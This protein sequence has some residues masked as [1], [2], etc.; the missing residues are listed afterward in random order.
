MMSTEMA[1]NITEMAEMNTENVDMTTEMAENVP[2]VAENNQLA[3]TNE[4]K[5]ARLATEIN[6]IKI[7]TQAVIQNATLEIGRRLVQ[8][9]AAVPHGCWGQWLKEKVDYS[10]RTAQMLISTFER[11]GNG[12]Q[13]L[14]GKTAD[15]E[16][17]AQLNRSQ[18][19][20]LM[21]IKNEDDCIAFMDEHKEDLPSMSKRELEQAIKER[22]QAKADIE[23]WR[24]RCNDLTDT[25]EKAAQRAEKLKAELAQLKADTAAGGEEL[26]K[27]KEENKALQQTIEL[28]KRNASDSYHD[29]EEA[30]RQLAEEKAKYEEELKALEEAHENIDNEE[31]RKVSAESAARAGRIADLEKEI[32]ELKKAQPAPMPVEKTQEEKDFIRHFENC[33]T[34]FTALMNAMG[35]MQVENQDKYRDKMRKMLELMSGLVR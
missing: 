19:F 6:T 7:Q 22:D 25:A 1:E 27:L 32:E 23:A 10:E 24:S 29:A 35:T 8:A 31:L 21:S 33:K 2:E 11:F 20:A 34:E 15:P 12:Q 18:M 9:K 3:E 16:L 5:L 13:K 17:L 30:Q 4:D 14:F 26:D 28:E